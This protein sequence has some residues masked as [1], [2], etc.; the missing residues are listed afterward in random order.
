MTTD[1]I[2]ARLMTLHP[3]VIDL[4]LGRIQRLLDALG[5][6]EKKLPPVVHV[7]GTNGKGSLVAYTRAM[8]EAAG[9]KVHAYISPHLVH[10]NERIR[11]AGELID[12][13]ELEAVLEECEQANDGRPITYFEI[14]TAAAFLAFARHPADLLAL[15]VGLGGRF[16]ATNV[17]DRP[18]VTAITPI[19]IDHTQF[20]GES[21]RQIAH[22]KSGIFKRAVP[23]VIGRQRPEPA[24][25]F[26]EDAHALDVPLYRMGQEWRVEPHGDGFRYRSDALSLDLP[27]PKLV[28]AHQIDNAGTAVAVAERLRAQG[29]IIGDAAIRTGLAT[30]EW[31]ARLQQLTRGPLADALPPGCELWLDGGHNEDCGLVLAEQARTWAREPG[32]LP[33]YLIFG[34][35][36]TK[37]AGGFLRPLAR[38]AV[39]AR[40]VPVPDHASYTPEEACRR[41]DDVGLHCLPAASVPDALDDLLA[42]VHPPFRVLICGS[43]YLAGV[44]LKKN[45]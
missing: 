26:V 13:L 3:R 2:L 25:L 9:L 35:L 20:F 42:N 1:A 24:A 32:A 34:M 29:L 22:E 30:V 38:H 31:P 10:F 15:E 4:E 40:A 45:G 5:N 27:R 37:D 33:L 36:T 18:A 23:A 43:L 16:D 12:D 8:A 41:A 17:I 11:L 39:S 19:G 14:T 7:A 28:G 21:L 44:V 6:P